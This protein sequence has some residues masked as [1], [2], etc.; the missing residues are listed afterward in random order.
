MSVTVLPTFKGYTVDLRLQEFRRAIAENTL[1]FISFHTPEGE[2]LFRE[3]KLF[4]EEILDF[5]SYK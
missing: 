1:E 4:A 2:K 3:L 5:Y